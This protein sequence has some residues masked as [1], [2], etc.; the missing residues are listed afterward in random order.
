MDRDTDRQKLEG[1]E[2][3]GKIG[4]TKKGTEEKRYKRT[5]DGQIDREREREREKERMNE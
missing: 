3:N 5:T 2:E 4:Q 1:R